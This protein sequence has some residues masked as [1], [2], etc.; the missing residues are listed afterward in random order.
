M[1][2]VEVISSA[3]LGR[4]DLVY[5]LIDSWSSYNSLHCVRIAHITGLAQILGANLSD[6]PFIRQIHVWH[7]TTAHTTTTKTAW[8]VSVTWEAS[9]SFEN[10]LSA[11]EWTQLNS[12]MNSFCL[13][14]LETPI[15]LSQAPSDLGSW[16][17]VVLFKI[18]CR[19]GFSYS[20]RVKLLKLCL[21]EPKTAVA[22]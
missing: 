8:S 2:N 10:S 6:G 12:W 7:R 1:I 15:R 3:F 19:L 16:N 11:G 14:L 17:R 18:Y 20:K 4:G 13:S 5:C 21:Y 9:T 22:L